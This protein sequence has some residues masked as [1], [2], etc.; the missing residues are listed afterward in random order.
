MN[1]LGVGKCADCGNLRV[2]DPEGVVEVIVGGGEGA[3]G[4][5]KG[6]SSSSSSGGGGGGGGGGAPPTL[7]LRLDESPPSGGTGGG[8][9]GA[10]LL[11]G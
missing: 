8:G 1:G 10:V 11:E 9:L 5:A 4:P 6:P 2:I 7:E 3:R